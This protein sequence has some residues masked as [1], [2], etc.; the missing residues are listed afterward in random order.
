MIERQNDSNDSVVVIF[1]TFPSPDVARQIGTHLVGLQLAACINIVP[2][3][4]SIYEWE[5]KIQQEN[6]VLGIFKT[7]R[8]KIDALEI[9][10]QDEHPYEVPEIIVMP[11]VAGAKNY[12][13]WVRSEVG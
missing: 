3:I 12:L 10:L 13:N 5:G 7:T 6:E 8:E 11:L 9:A 4:E 1:C 2:G